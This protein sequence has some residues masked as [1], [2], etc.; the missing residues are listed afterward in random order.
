MQFFPHEFVI[1]KIKLNRSVSNLYHTFQTT[2]MKLVDR[3]CGSSALRSFHKYMPPAYTINSN[4]FA[5][6]IGVN[7]N[8]RIHQFCI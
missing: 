7:G 5:Y 8:W 1:N 3:F 6:I 4:E 2:A